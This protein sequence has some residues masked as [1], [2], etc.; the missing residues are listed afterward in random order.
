VRTLTI[1]NGVVTASATNGA[2]IGAGHGYALD[3]GNGESSVTTIAITNGTVTATASGGAG[4]GSAS[5]YGYETLSY[6]TSSVGTIAITAGVINAKGG[7]GAGIGVGHGSQG[8][9]GVG[10]STVGNV[11]FLGKVELTVDCDSTHRPIAA[12][13]I[14]FSGASVRATTASL[15]LLGVKPAVFTASDI[16][17]LYRRVT[18]DLTLEPLAGLGHFLQVGDV[19]FPSQAA[20]TLTVEKAGFT[21]SFVVDSAVAKSFTKSVGGTGS[22][23]ITAKAAGSN[24]GGKLETFEGDQTFSVTGDGVTFVYG[25]RLPRAAAVAPLIVEL[26]QN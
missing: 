3:H 5:G 4:I 14:R 21:S 12:T 6:G 9:Y 1:S 7:D 25:A 2:G 17:F 22:Y 8:D 11:S 19:T 24:A 23:T 20:W 15:P 16:A 26:Q 18:T 10:Q 13:A